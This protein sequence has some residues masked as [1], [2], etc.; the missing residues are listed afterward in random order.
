MEINIKTKNFKLTPFIE[1]YVNKKIN[2]L[3]K[4]LIEE[5]FGIEVFVE[6]EKTTLHH[7][8]GPF[9]RAEGQMKV[10]GKNLRTEVV[11]EDLYLA[12]NEMK[13]ELQRELK[14]Y[15]NKLIS[16]RKKGMRTIKKEI[17]E[18]L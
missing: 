13:D 16:K 8:K 5:K 12:V 11:F 3:G 6:I 17:R 4:F 15:K 10:P 9:F 7:K 2:S 14:E 18:E 1:E